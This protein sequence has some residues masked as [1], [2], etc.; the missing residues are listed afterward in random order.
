MVLKVVRTN[1]KKKLKTVKNKKKILKLMKK[2]KI[3]VFVL[4]I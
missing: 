4:I 1:I 2:K 3:I